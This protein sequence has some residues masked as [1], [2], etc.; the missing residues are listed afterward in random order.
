LPLQIIGAGFGRTGTNSLKLA[1]EQLGFGP[2]YHMFE[3]QKRPQDMPFW[4]QAIYGETVDWE[5][6]FG[7][8]RSAVDWPV[9]A[10]W[11]PLSNAYPKAKIILTE[12][13]PEQWYESS[14]STIF[15][16]MEQPADDLK[17]HRRVLRN[18]VRELIFRQFFADRHHDK[19]H[20][21][22]TYLAHNARVRQ[23]L[24]AERLLCF[25][26]SQGWE[27]LCA[28]L[29]VNVPDTPYPVTN[30]RQDFMR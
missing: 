10:F 24:P 22:R 11:E 15:K 27:P 23:T 28:F 30:T 8:F 9:C 18:L 21:I 5:R 3:L 12:R 13:D 6:L 19:D 29:G 25:E 2:C 20:A 17:E 16:I 1:L 14:M 4:G 26:S 7:E